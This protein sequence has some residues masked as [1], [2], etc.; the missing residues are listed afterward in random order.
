MAARVCDFVRMNPPKLLGSQFGK[1]PTEVHWWGQENIGVMQV[2]SSDRWN[3]HPINYGC[4]SHMVKFTKWKDNRDD[5]V[6]YNS[7]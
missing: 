5:F 1:G 4:D 7:I 2:T 3:W 6:F